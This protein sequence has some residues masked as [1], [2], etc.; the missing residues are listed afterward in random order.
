[1]ANRMVTCMMTSHD[2]EKS[3][4][5]HDSC[6]QLGFLF[7]RAKRRYEVPTDGPLIE[8]LK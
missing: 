3:S 5:G 2:P 6:R 4:Q 8:G 7:L 1:M